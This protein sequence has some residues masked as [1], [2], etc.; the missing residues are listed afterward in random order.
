MV[1]HTSAFMT[2]LLI[3]PGVNHGIANGIKDGMNLWLTQPNVKTKLLKL[4]QNLSS[5]ERSLAKAT[6]EDFPK[7]LVNFLLGILLQDFDPN[8]RTEDENEEED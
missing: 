2:A 1:Y 4:Q 8:G 5:D 7:V 6:G 3:D